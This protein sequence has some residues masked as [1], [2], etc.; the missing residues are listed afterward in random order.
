MGILDQKPRFKVTAPK[1]RRVVK[2][3]PVEPRPAIPS[4]STGSA[5]PT[6]S[7]SSTSQSS[8]PVVAGGSSARSSETLSASPRTSTSPT[9]RNRASQSP[10]P[11]SGSRNGGDRKRKLASRP[12]HRASPAVS[13]RVE[14]GN[15]SDTDDDDWEATLHER[16][17]RKRKR[18]DANQRVDLDRQLVHPVLLETL[19]KSKEDEK[20]KADAEEGLGKETGAK[21][22]VKKAEKVD[23]GRDLRRL[24]IIHAKDVAS[25]A[26]K[27]V[28]VLG[29]SE[30][31]VSVELQYPGSRHRESYELVWGKDKIDAVKDIKTTIKHITE[32]YFTDEQAAPFTDSTIGIIRQIERASS[33]AVKDVK[34]FKSALEDFNKRL[35][36]LHDDGSIAANLAKRHDLPRH[37]VA[38]VLDQVYDRTVAPK[39]ELL[40]KYENGSD[41]VY[42][43]LLHPFITDILVDRL[44]MTSGQVFVDLGSGVGNVV[45]QAALEIGCESWGCE[46]M[47]NACNL[48]DEQKKEFSERCRLWG[49][50]PGKVRLERGDFRQN[51]P[52]LEALKRA[53]VVLVNNQAFTSQLNDDLVRMFLDFKSG[54]KIVSLKS[55]VHDHKSASHNI[56]DVGS[57]ILEVET[58]TYPEEFVSW[59]GAAGTFCISTRQ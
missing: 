14:F 18:V 21:D 57:A 13:D 48:A 41:N 26:L 49:I 30:D 33:D 4:R 47:E 39:V 1:I 56:N 52:I 25:I 17:H 58:L 19:P 36:A 51:T 54:C 27:C 3:I 6:I 12:A 15:D 42:G 24:K 55:F 23:G 10:L 59:T 29:A 2:Q 40:R 22:S 16:E 44:Q 5:P 45:L 37:F 9:N 28:P 46:M 53:D 43:E 35:L 11:G 7:R 31:E 8:R 32:V 50:A 34:M 38:F 20:A